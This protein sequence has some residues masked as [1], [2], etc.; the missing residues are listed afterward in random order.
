M[1]AS[2][3]AAYGFHAD[4]PYRLTEEWPVRPAAHLFY[5]QEKAEIERLL[6]VEAE[7]HPQLG[8]YLLRPP[9]VLGPHALG[10]KDLLPGPLAP[11]ARGLGALVRRS[12]PVPVAVPDLPL[13][14]VDEDDVGQALLLSVVGAGPPGAYNLA[15]DGVLSVHDVARELELTPLPSRNA[16]CGPAPARLRACRSRHRSPSGRRRSPGTRSWTRPRPGANSA[17]SPGTPVS[18]RCAGRSRTMKA[19]RVRRGLRRR[20]SA[21]RGGG[22]TKVADAA[23]EEEC[24]LVLGS[25]GGGMN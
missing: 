18:T 20:A 4:N 2:S 12:V 10:A 13:Q 19:P 9:V 8:L 7:L 24:W 21:V 25:G 14:F 15:G 17:G 16:R 1:Y 6:A 22:Q 23:E 11:L 5:A 3:V